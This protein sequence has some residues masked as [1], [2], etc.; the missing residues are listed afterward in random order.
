MHGN[1]DLFTFSCKFSKKWGFKMNVIVST[2][3]ILDQ[4]KLRHFQTIQKEILTTFSEG[5]G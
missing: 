5:N 4:R 1:E 3:P 2:V